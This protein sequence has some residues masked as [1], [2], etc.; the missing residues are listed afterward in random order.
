MNKQDMQIAGLKRLMLLTCGTNSVAKKSNTPTIKLV[1]I[2][3]QKVA[4]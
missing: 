3:I 4:V 1:K 2:T